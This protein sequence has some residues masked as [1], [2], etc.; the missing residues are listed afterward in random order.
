L[1]E[2]DCLNLA[3]YVL[4]VAGDGIGK[5]KAGQILEKALDPSLKAFWQQ[6]GVVLPWAD[7]LDHAKVASD[8]A[9][10]LKGYV[11]STP[12]HK[13]IIDGAI[14]GWKLGPKAGQHLGSLVPEMATAP[15]N[16]HLGVA[17]EYAVMSE[18]AATGWNVAKLALDD[19]VDV[20]ATKGA[21][22]RT[23]Q[24]KTSKMQLLGDGKMQFS[25]SITSSAT[26]A[27]I[28]HYFVLV[29]RQISGQGWSNTFFIERSNDFG[30]TINQFGQPNHQTGKWTLD[31][32]RRGHR[33]FIGGTR[34]I[35]EHLGQ[36]ATRFI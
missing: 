16:L 13:R 21:A 15:S 9:R 19:G 34:D 32:V 25:G 3:T 18:L 35:T 24:V 28:N 6:K 4:F 31:V 30:H 27:S 12:Q 8:I 1:T 29:F 5:L 20:F 36:F 23:V 22:V 26:Y 7:G 11:I 14:S 2:S 17:G 33:F 10:R